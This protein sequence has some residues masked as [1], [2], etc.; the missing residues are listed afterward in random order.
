MAVVYNPGTCSAVQGSYA[1]VFSTHVCPEWPCPGSSLLGGSLQ[2][3]SITAWR[4]LAAFRVW[5]LVCSFRPTHPCPEENTEPALQVFV[6]VQAGCTGAQGPELESQAGEAGGPGGTL[7]AGQEHH[8]QPH[9]ALL[10]PSGAGSL[11]LMAGLSLLMASVVL[12]DESC[13]HQV[14]VLPGSACCMPA[15]LHSHGAAYAPS[16]ACTS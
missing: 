2:P 10:R 15:P 5:C 3:G 7:R 12:C 4:V 9:T 14:R 8:R 11:P 16:S 6:S 13:P 1:E